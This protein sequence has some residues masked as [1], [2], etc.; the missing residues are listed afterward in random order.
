MTTYNLPIHCQIPDCETLFSD[1]QN[2][3]YTVCNA[4]SVIL[5]S[6]RHFV[7]N[8][9]QG[10]V[11]RQI[12][13]NEKNEFLRFQKEELDHIPNNQEDNLCEA[14]SDRE[15]DHSLQKDVFMGLFQNDRLVASM[16]FIPRPEEWQNNL[17]DLDMSFPHGIDNVVIVDSILVGQSHRGYGIQHFLFL[18]AE[19]WARSHGFPLLCGVA[20]PKN[21]HSN[22]NFQKSGYELVATKPKYH[23]V[24]NFYLRKL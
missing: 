20:S 3:G 6:G 4:D 22:A 17:P 18:V 19:S 15:I 9:E 13:P 2:L 10:L 12:R 16:L 8:L 7:E 11:L 5:L 23:S 24:R 1:F 14:L 21:T